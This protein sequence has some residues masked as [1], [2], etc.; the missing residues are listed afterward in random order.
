MTQPENSAQR[1]IVSPAD[2]PYQIVVYLEIVVAAVR[3]S[4]TAN[5]VP[6]PLVTAGNA[7]LTAAVSFS[8]SARCCFLTCSGVSG[9]S[10]LP[11][12]SFVK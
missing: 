7:A 11:L 5:A 2:A 8:A 3:L 12:R 1:P 6:L 9:I 4:G 10:V